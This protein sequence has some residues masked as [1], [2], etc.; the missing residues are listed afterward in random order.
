MTK[1]IF[2]PLIF[3]AVCSSRF[4]SADAFHAY[5]FQGIFSMQ[6]N[7]SDVHPAWQFYIYAALVLMF[8]VFSGYALLGSRRRLKR[9]LGSLAF[10]LLKEP[11]KYL[12]DW[13]E[14]RRKAKLSGASAVDLEKQPSP[15]VGE[16]RVVLKWAASSGR[17]DVV[18][19]IL[20]TSNKKTKLM[21]GTSGHALLLA[22]QNGHTEA[23][24]LLID[25]G[26]GTTYLTT[27]PAPPCS[28]G[29]RGWANLQS[30]KRFSE[31][32]PYWARRIAEARLP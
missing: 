26:E 10:W 13:S 23:A 12:S 22:I 17:T 27:K 20:E 3:T 24:N 11:V 4:P 1:F 16:A 6:V 31:R 18:R 14:K 32:A 5:K 7:L 2:L 30:A 28:I 8:V 19:N 29:Q 9:F 15:S 21:P 25:R